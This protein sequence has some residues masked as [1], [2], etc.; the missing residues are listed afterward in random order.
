MA[1]AKWDAPTDIKADLDAW[2]TQIANETGIDTKPKPFEVVR[3][4]WRAQVQELYKY[5]WS[6]QAVVDSLI[7]NIEMIKEQIELDAGQVGPR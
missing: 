5:G 6:S 7:R 1:V 3:D 2:A 4:D